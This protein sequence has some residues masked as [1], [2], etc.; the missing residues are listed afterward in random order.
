MVKSL[1]V[2]FALGSAVAAAAAP[3]PPVEVMVLG[4]YHFGNPGLDTNNMITDSVLTPQKQAELERVARALAAFQPTHVMVEMQ[5]DAPN[6]AI[7]EYGR[8][9][10][11]MLA[12]DANEIVQIGYR[13]ARVAGLKTVNG[14]DEQPK[15]GEPDYYPY[16]KV[17]ETAAKFGQTKVLEAVNAPVAAWVKDFEGRQRTLSIGQMLMRMN[18]PAGIQGAMDSYYGMLPIGDKDTQTGADLNAG[19]FLRNAKIFGKLMQVAKPGDRVLVVYGGG[20][21]FWLRHFASLTPGFRN[22]DVLPYLKK[23]N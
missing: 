8:F 15:D 3:T 6:F 16:D 17:Q 12:K 2:V 21:G 20:H 13:T 22:V 9:D 14:I 18:D 11:A 1:L 5:S 4:A 7:G 23:A 10:D 19:W